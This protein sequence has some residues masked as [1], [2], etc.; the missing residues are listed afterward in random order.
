[1]ISF[2]LDTTVQTYKVNKYNKYIKY[3][4]KNSYIYSELK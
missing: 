2:N 4:I 3:Y 1:M